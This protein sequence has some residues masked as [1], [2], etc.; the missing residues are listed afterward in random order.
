MGY[1]ETHPLISPLP[2]C[3]YLPVTEQN[4]RAVHLESAGQMER[5][6]CRELRKKKKPLDSAGVQEARA[7]ET[8]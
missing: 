5:S 6:L 1:G 4:V 8:P 2:V 7:K 3:R